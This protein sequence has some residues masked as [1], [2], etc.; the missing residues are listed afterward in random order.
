[1]L[2]ASVL[3][4]LMGSAQATAGC[5]HPWNALAPAAGSPNGWQYEVIADGGAAHLVVN[6]WLP[7]GSAALLVV[8]PG[9]EPFLRD[10]EVEGARGW[11]PL[12]REGAALL[13]PECVHACH[14]RYQFALRSAADALS[15]PDTA[16]AWNEVI[17]APPSAWLLHPSL[18]PPRMRYRLHV[19]TP[20]G[21]SFATGIFLAPEDEGQN[22][23]YEADASTLG[24]APYAVFGPL[25]EHRLKVA[26][27]V[28]MDLVGGPA[29]FD[30]GEE[31]LAR[32]VT[33]SAATVARFFG[34]FP[35]SRAMVLVAPAPGDQVR[36]GETMGDGGA[37][38]VLELGEHASQVALDADWILPH[39]MT[40]LAIPSVSKTHHWI[41]EG[42]AVYFEPIARARAGMLSPEE[43][44]LT[45]LREMP[46]GLPTHSGEGLDGTADW[47]RTYWGGAL[48]CLLADLEIRRRSGNRLGLDDA[49]RGVLA[50]G[51]SVAEVWPFDHLLE[52]A[53]GAVGVTVLRPLHNGMGRAAWGFDLARL[54][55][56]LGVREQRDRV[57]LVDD[58]PLAALRRAITEPLRE[59]PRAIEACHHPASATVAHR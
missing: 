39:E 57:T 8:S 7:A 54:F 33:R 43:V 3:A 36:H 25:H 19:R 6:A 40:H 59:S 50:E 47:R 22:T 20:E 38:I 46:R 26:P 51:G 27:G 28:E 10:A 35:V 49:L 5:Q 11:R 15:N 18:A 21:L 52:V 31:A 12:I 9:A 2:R 4:A 44:W 30:V 13:A 48:F 23:V 37:S 32:W 56:D 34:C 41:E 1:M 45:F 17:E 29:S 16:V 53:D 42:L 14:I 24:V 58:A 55:G